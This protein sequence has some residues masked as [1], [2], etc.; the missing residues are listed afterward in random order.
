MSDTEN[1]DDNKERARDFRDEALRFLNKNYSTLELSD[2]FRTKHNISEKSNSIVVEIFIRPNEYNR[3]TI[4]KDELRR[5]CEEIASVADG[6]RPDW[7]TSMNG[8]PNYMKVL[9]YTAS[10]G[11]PVGEIEYKYLN[12][13]YER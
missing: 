5:M 9:I 1:N 13:D 6:N 4:D 12:R 8:Y 3:T 10:L 2:D 7:L 11:Y